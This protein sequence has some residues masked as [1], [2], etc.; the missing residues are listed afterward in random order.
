[1]Q[2]RGLSLHRQRQKRTRTFDR[3]SKSCDVNLQ[4]HCN[5]P[6]LPSAFGLPCSQASELSLLRR[7]AAHRA[8]LTYQLQNALPANWPHP[9]IDGVKRQPQRAP[10]TNNCLHMPVDFEM[11]NFGSDGQRTH[12]ARAGDND[13]PQ[14]NAASANARQ[15][16][17][18]ADT[19]DGE[20]NRFRV[21]KGQYGGGWRPTWQG[22][23]SRA[24]PA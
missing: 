13:L 18:R 20:T 16:K 21:L 4:H 15:Q 19:D 6:G 5:H 7:C 24:K 12:D 14:R 1:M 10:A 22:F 3:R 8:R 23:Q 11:R 9:P 17:M 2:I